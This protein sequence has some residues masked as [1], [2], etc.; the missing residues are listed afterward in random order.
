MAEKFFWADAIADR[1]IKEKTLTK[2]KKEFVCASGITP[3]GTIHIG[4]FREVIT[5]DLVVKAL[6]DK[7]EKV[8][9]IYSWDDFDRFRKV[10]SGVDQSY[11]KYI[12]MP[13]SDIPSP[14]DK[15]KSYAEYNEKNF[16]NSLTQVNISPEFIYQNKMNKKCK[17]AK[18][19]KVALDKRKEIIKILDKYRKEP[20]KDDWMPIMIYCD[21]CK[22]DTTKIISHKDYEIEYECN[23]GFKEKF[24]FRKKGII[25]IRW[26]V[27]WPLRWK[28][29]GVDFEP[30]GIDHSVEGGSFT[31]SKEIS[32]KVFDYQ[33]PI[34]QFY[35]WINIKGMAL[36]DFH[37]SKGKIMT[38]DE[39]LEIYEP[40]ILRY[41]FVSTRPNKAFEISLDVG[42]IKIY[43]DYDKLEQ[44]YFGKRLD[45]QQK[46]IYEL[47]Q[48]K[49]V[50]KSKPEKL[51]FRHL[52]T[53]VQIGKIKDLNSESKKRAE[54]VK[55][56]LKKYAPEDFKFEVQEKLK[57][58][59]E[60]TDKKSL[61]E[62]RKLLES[63]DFTEEELFNEFYN[64]CQKLEI[65]NTDF[66]KTC[67]QAIIGKDKGPRLASL[68]LAIGKEKVIKL[69]EQIK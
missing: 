33:Y 34:Y 66:F 3:S 56:W 49:K 52:T 36:K 26:R 42:V 40:E 14:F 24:D 1:I 47:S 13:I 45:E 38:L 32:K 54:K 61:I 44:D 5:T 55:N 39:V 68:I 63:K 67:Y 7:G 28:Y 22:K 29:E 4:N 11:E 18:L 35:E 41:I 19:I 50:K 62:L 15:N 16:E 12:G 69:L 57:F 58:P 64:I 48:I 53:L 27:D 8:K 6:K 31:T 46:R 59:F 25:S 20:L 51:S 37:S 23:C 2:G 17:Y 9:F 65:K 60:G 43:E 10:P 21:K 30:G